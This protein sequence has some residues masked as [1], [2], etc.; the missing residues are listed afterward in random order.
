MCTWLVS[1]TSLLGR[2]GMTNGSEVH[3]AVG[4]VVLAANV[5]DLLGLHSFE[6]GAIRDPMAKASTEGTA[7]FSCGWREGSA[8]SQDQVSGLRSGPQLALP[9]RTGFLVFQSVCLTS[10]KVPSCHLE[11]RALLHTHLQCPA[12]THPH[13][14]ALAEQVVPSA[15]LPATRL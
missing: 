3:G 6:F 15:W 4:Q 14:V 13:S 1:W 8:R 7:P 12:W 11:T 10:P 2:R 9:A 5:A